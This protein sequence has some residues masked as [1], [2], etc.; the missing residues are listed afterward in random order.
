MNSTRAQDLGA[1]IYD[2]IEIKDR[3]FRLKNYYST[4]L[5]SEVVS[6]IQNSEQCTEKE[7]LKI[8]NLLIRMKIFHHVYDDHLLEN[9]KL[10]YRF[11]KDEKSTEQKE[12]ETTGTG[13]GTGTDV[14]VEHSDATLT[15]QQQ[16]IQFRLSV[17]K[18][19]ADAE[20]ERINLRLQCEG[21]LLEQERSIRAL[22][23]I[24][25]VLSLTLASVSLLQL[26]IPNGWLGCSVTVLCVGYML[27]AI[28]KSAETVAKRHGV[29]SLLHLLVQTNNDA[30]GGVDPEKNIQS[31]PYQNNREKTNDT[32]EVD[33]EVELIPSSY[34]ISKLLVE[35]EDEISKLMALV[36]LPKVIDPYMKYDRIFY[37]RYILSF[38]SAEKATNAIEFTFQFR[39]EKKFQQLAAKLAKE[40]EFVLLPGV[41]EAKKWQV[42]APL[43]NVLTKET[44]GGVAVLIRMGMCN[45]AMMHDR[46]VSLLFNTICSQLC[47]MHTIEIY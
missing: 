5:G 19:F 27:H 38:G 47:R 4:C 3:R 29:S 22:L 46:M 18:E 39:A 10:F 1:S 8:G 24:V 23:S 30:M 42:G 17:H 9:A 13:T 40:E 31:T 16:L 2:N 14:S 7:A 28:H 36:P 41:V 20:A 12:K 34:D 37:L 6:Y 11:Y 21:Q 32:T 43:N 44:G 15:T 26:C 25:V 35:H 45:M 33:N